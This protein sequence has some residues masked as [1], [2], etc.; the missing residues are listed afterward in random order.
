MKG[1]DSDLP[2]GKCFL[3]HVDKHIPVTHQKTELPVNWTASEE[4]NM[5]GHSGPRLRGLSFW[6]L[7]EKETGGNFHFF[8]IY[9]LE[10]TE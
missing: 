2:L 1:R 5:K 6:Y 7:K 8:Q 9:F 4:E 10:M 3:Y